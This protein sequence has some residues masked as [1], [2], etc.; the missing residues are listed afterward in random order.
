MEM[1]MEENE[2][3]ARRKSGFG[4]GTE[5]IRMLYF[6]LKEGESAKAHW[7]SR[8]A[9]PLSEIGM[10]E[11]GKL[12][13]C[14]VPEYYVGKRAWGEERLTESLNGLIH[15][16]AC[17]EYYL[18]PE[19]AGIIGIR[20][21]VFPPFLLL[22]VLLRQVPCMEY[23]CCIG[24]EGEQDLLRE[25][26]E[27]YLPRI[28]HVRVISGNPQAYG[29]FGEYIYGEFGIPMACTASLDKSAGRDGKTVILDIERNYRIPWSACPAGAV[30][31][32]FWSV[33]EKEKLLGKFRRDVKYL[34]VVK[35]LDTIAKNGYNSTVNWSSGIK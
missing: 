11:T 4:S 18:Q 19:L 33:A 15:R 13:C 20:E 2:K 9:L 30:Y 8:M 28:N 35:F 5:N 32:D 6:S 10:G 22:D 26:L 21:P 16:A 31:V 3:K 25:L 27:P 14:P 24:W 1:E 34:S 23:V 17:A 29:E 7:W 12:L